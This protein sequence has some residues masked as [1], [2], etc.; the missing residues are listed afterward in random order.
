MLDEIV[1]DLIRK[2][3]N[4]SMW[5]LFIVVLVKFIL[6][7]IFDVILEIIKERKSK[8]LQSE[9]D[10]KNKVQSSII[11]FEKYK[12]DLVLPNLERIATIFGKKH[13]HIKNYVNVLEKNFNTN[14]RYGV[15]DNS[16][17]TRLIEEKIELF[18]DFLELKNKVNIYL[19]KEFRT[20][21][22]QFHVTLEQDL[23][24]I[25]DFEEMA[26]VSLQQNDIRE[27]SRNSIKVFLVL[28]DCY[29]E[30]IANYIKFPAR[31]KEY[32]TILLKY[33]LYIKDGNILYYSDDYKWVNITLN[34]KLASLEELKRSSIWTEIIMVNYSKL[35]I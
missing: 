11:E 13:V 1:A 26:K 22:L 27:I 30:M 34:L 18:N 15:Y 32:S 10:E 2:F 17:F 33:G 3:G 7:P 29:Y 28:L 20:L 14:S 24:R 25:E 9:I 16:E 23:F 19:P 21:L 4:G 6:K 31:E 5:A 12:K 35:I 8:L